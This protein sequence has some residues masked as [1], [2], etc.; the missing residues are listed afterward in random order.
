MRIECGGAGPDRRSFAG[1]NEL[2]LWLRR[3]ET[4]HQQPDFISPDDVLIPSNQSCLVD[5]I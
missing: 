3:R 1:G 2:E 4:L 5:G